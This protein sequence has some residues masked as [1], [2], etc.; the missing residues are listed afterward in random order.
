[1]PVCGSFSLYA[2]P[3]MWLRRSMTVTFRPNSRA[4]RSAM[5]RP[6]KPDPT[7]TRSVF[8]GLSMDRGT[9]QDTRRAATNPE[10]STG[11][12]P[13]GGAGGPGV[14]VVVAAKPGFVAEL[15]PECCG[16]RVGVQPA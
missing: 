15:I 14:G 13:P 16:D 9:V 4:Q 1:M 11:T 10:C 7:T 5:V 12:L 6:K 2:F 8:T 3:P